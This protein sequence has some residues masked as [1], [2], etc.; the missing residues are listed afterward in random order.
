M[1][2]RSSQPLDSAPA[3]C[4]D[5]K[6][7]KRK[8][9]IFDLELH[10][11]IGRPLT[12]LTVDELISASLSMLHFMTMAGYDVSGYSRH[13]Q[14]ISDRSRSYNTP[15]LI[16]YD[17]AVREQAEYLGLSAFSYGNNELFYEFLGVENLKP[18]G[19]GNSQNK[20]P[21]PGKS[22]KSG[23]KKMGFCWNYNSSKGCS[24]DPCLHKHECTNCG[25]HHRAIDCPADKGSS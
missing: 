18:R 1:L 9:L 16:R 7:R 20:K 17:Q 2:L 22:P 8:C 4:H 15:A 10:T 21:K 5:D 11:P 23:N 24:D 19:T 3:C 25:G 6:R 12:S 13:I 14:F